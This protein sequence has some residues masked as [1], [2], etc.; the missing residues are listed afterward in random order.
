MDSKHK[1]PGSMQRKGIPGHLPGFPIPS[2][3]HNF[4]LCKQPPNAHAEKCGLTGS[5][6]S[7]WQIAADQ[8]PPASIQ[9]FDSFRIVPY[10]HV[11]FHPRIEGR[12][13]IV[14]DAGW[15]AVDA[16]GPKT[17]S[18]FRVRK[19]PCGSGAPMHASS[20]RK[21]PKVWR[22]RRWQELVHREEH[23]G[24]RKATAQGRLA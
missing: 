8:Y 13:A 7:K 19:K 22:G 23:G 1:R 14:T 10:V 12:I 17:T 18:L 5:T 3:H 20:S 9:S 2:L 24:H 4:W 15:N 6:L 11:L 21:T 16:E